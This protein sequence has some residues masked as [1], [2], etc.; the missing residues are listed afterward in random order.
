VLIHTEGVVFGVT[1][2]QI[3]FAAQTLRRAFTRLIIALSME[4]Q[5]VHNPIHLGCAWSFSPT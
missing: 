2:A 1:G 4:E 3:E 5:H